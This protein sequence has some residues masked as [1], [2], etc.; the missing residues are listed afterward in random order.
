MTD[1]LTADLVERVRVARRIPS[2]AMA[3]EIL[4][5]AGVSQGDAASVLRVNRVTLNGWINGRHR[6]RGDNLVRYVALLEQLQEAAR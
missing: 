2:P 3:Q 6:P 4:R 5:A 1:L